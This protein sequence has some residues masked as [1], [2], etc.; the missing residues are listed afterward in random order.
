MLSPITIP[1]LHYAVTH[2]GARP[3][4]QVTVYVACA[5]LHRTSTDR[6]YTSEVLD[7]TTAPQRV[8]EAIEKEWNG[9]LEREL[10]PAVGVILAGPSTHSLLI[11]RVTATS[12]TCNTSS[13]WYN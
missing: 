12:A 5:L 2:H 11:Q 3:F 9:V 13:R 7:P 4:P 8:A 1:S 6:Y 10:H